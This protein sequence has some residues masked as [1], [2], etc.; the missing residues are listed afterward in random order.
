M[1]TLAWSLQTL[2]TALYSK[3]GFYSRLER[4]RCTTPA[5]TILEWLDMTACNIRRP[6]FLYQYPPASINI[7][8]LCTSLYQ[9]EMT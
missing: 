2:T 7:H 3:K 4:H 5:A 9:P 1:E 8:I 6:R